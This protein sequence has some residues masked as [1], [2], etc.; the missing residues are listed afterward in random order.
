MQVTVDP[1]QA[2]EVRVKILAT[3]VCHTDL[4]TWEGSDPEMQI[5]CILVRSAADLLPCFASWSLC[6][7][8]PVYL[9]CLALL[10]G[11]EGIGIVESVGEGVT[12]C[13]VGGAHAAEL[14]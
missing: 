8:T 9:L 2:G 14:G 3:A 1:P 6:C 5:P 11:H 4:Y 7:L 13:K 10:Q 12:T